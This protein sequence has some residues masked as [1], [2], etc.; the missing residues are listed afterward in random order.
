MGDG[1]MPSQDCSTRILP[2]VFGDHHLSE[3]VDQGLERQAA[4][5]FSEENAFTIEKCFNFFSP[6]K[7]TFSPQ[8]IFNPL[9]LNEDSRIRKNRLSKL[10]YRFQ[11]Y[12]SLIKTV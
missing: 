2:V 11:R 10:H 6:Q 9:F 7:I 8:S 3:V 4:N 1:R 5:C 12:T